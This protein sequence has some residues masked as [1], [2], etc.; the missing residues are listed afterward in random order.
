MKSAVIIMNLGSPIDTT[1]ASVRAFL[2]EFLSDRR[3]IEVP[4]L[5][6][7]IILH[8]IILVF[9][10][11]KV[12]KAYQKI[13]LSEGSPLRV[14]TQQQV[15][16][17]QQQLSA[18]MGDEAPVVRYAMTYTGPSIA[19]VVGELNQQGIEHILVLPLYP[20]YSATTVGSIYD[21][22]S[23]I[24]S[25]SRNIPQIHVI[26]SYYQ[27]S[28]YIEALAYSVKEVWDESGKADHLLMSFH[29]IPQSYSDKGD[30]YFYECMK[31]ANLLA[32][33]LGLTESEWEVSFQSKVGFSKWLSPY[34]SSRV[35]KLAKEKVKSLEV[36]CPA[37]SVDCLETLEEIDME[38]RE[39]FLENGGEKFTMIPCLNDKDCHIDMMSGLVE[40]YLPTH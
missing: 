37:F 15:I 28:L 38:N 24:V 5:I 36:I 4:K 6:W 7:F 10:T 32:E 9:R 16:K 25:Q 22:I 26:K 2:K 21:Q 34:T 18:R 40:K 20:Q 31:T 8:C 14:T 12:V 19:Q 17:L 3:V 11:P 35:E 29:S 33:K 13:W 39:I 27:Y 23:A 1:P 30:P